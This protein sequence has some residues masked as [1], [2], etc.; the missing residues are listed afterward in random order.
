M[1]ITRPGPFQLVLKRK[2]LPSALKV[3]FLVGLI[4]V[5]FYV[6]FEIGSKPADVELLAYIK[7]RLSEEKY[8][9]AVIIIVP[10]FL[11]KGVWKHLGIAIAGEEFHFD[12]ATQTINANGKQF[13]FADVEYLRL[14]KVLGDGE[15]S[16]MFYLAMVVPFGKVNIESGTKMDEVATL[17]NEVAEV[18]NVKVVNE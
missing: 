12:G 3:L 14:Q 10:I 4:P 17:A 9:W 11:L 5:V 8:L 16:D 18:L 7:Y 2:R 13:P 6:S 15:S 1:I